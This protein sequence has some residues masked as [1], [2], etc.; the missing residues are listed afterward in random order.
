VLLP[1]PPEGYK[2]TTARGSPRR[3][4]GLS[5]TISYTQDRYLSK[6]GRT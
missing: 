5:M 4:I 1:G 3:K 6:I 2:S